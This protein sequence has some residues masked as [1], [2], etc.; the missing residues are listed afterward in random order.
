MVKNRGEGI[1]E[2]VVRVGLVGKGERDKRVMG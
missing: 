2:G 1:E